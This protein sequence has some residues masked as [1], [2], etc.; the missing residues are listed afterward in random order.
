M[1]ETISELLALVAAKK[2]TIG[3][4]MIQREM[5]VFAKTRDE[6]L[7]MMEQ[8]LIT[9]EKA[10]L[11]GMAGVRSR[12]GATGFDGKRLTDYLDKGAVLTD[13]TFVKALTIAVATNEVNASM[14]VICATPTAGSAGVVP[15]VL[16]AFQERLGASRE[17]LIEALFTAAAF[18][19]V[20]AN[21]AFIAGAEGGCQAEIGSA[22][23]MAAA[24]L[25][26]LA[27]GSP[28]ETAAAFAMALNNSIGLACDPVAGLVEIPCIK[29]NAGGAATAIA[30]AEMALAG[31][32]SEIPADEV[33][34]TMYRV[35]RS[36]P[37]EIRETGLGGLAAS[38][39]GKRIAKEL[40]GIEN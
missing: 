28:E 18:G 14:G 10:A 21:N 37:I 22:A 29:R 24:A 11:K 5:A 31:V 27:N 13:P 26:E 4:A 23:G 38:A 33:I 19:Y 32:I 40:F 17:A 6:V 30:A 8:N 16:L 7:D 39:T 34:E 20:T 12:S 9:M 3:E 36:M 25:V 35:G 15:G 1:F 2:I